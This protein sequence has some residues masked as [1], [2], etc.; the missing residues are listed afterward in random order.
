MD[1]SSK[2]FNEFKFLS[3]AAATQTAVL[4][5]ISIAALNNLIKYCPGEINSWLKYSQK[6][7]DSKISSI[8][9]LFCYGV[10]ISAVFIQTLI[11]ST[12]FI[13]RSRITKTNGLVN[14]LNRVVI[15][16]F[17]VNFL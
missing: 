17:V 12:N 7:T 15:T 3:N 13:K 16:N 10:L 5:G 8:K 1:Q 2:Y 14:K 4:T 6:N 11:L 9:S